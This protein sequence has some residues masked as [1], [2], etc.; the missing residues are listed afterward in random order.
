MRESGEEVLRNEDGG[1]GKIEQVNVSFSFRTLAYTGSVVFLAIWMIVLASWVFAKSRIQTLGDINYLLAML[2]TYFMLPL[3]VILPP[4]FR[5]WRTRVKVSIAL[6]LVTS[7]ILVLLVVTALSWAVVQPVVVVMY[8]ML[9]LSMGLLVVLM[10]LA[11][12]FIMSWTKFKKFQLGNLEGSDYV[13]VVPV[14]RYQALHHG[15]Q[16]LLVV[17]AA[18]LSTVGNGLEDGH[19]NSQGYTVPCFIGFLL[20][21]VQLRHYTKSHMGWFNRNRTKKQILKYV[22]QYPLTEIEKKLVNEK[23]HA[24]RIIEG[25]FTATLYPRPEV[26]PF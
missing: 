6:N 15:S 10:L 25:T 4:V 19:P 9:V 14:G 11:S 21:V 17:G 22:K 1:S 26:C 7:L 3:T 20:F 24:A 13:Q 2:I 5:K 23:R 12:L 8:N 16:V 18:L